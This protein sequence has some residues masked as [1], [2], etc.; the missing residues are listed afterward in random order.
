MAGM[1]GNHDRDDDLAREIR[2]HL[3]LEA[4][5]RV[6][7]GASP[8]EARVAARRAF[9]NVTRIREDARAMWTTPW[10][11]QAQQDV[12]YALRMF[13][14]T[15]GFSVVALLTF[16][17]GIGA[18]RPASA[19]STPF[20]CGRCRLRIPTASFAFP[21]TSRLPTG[22]AARRDAWDGSRGRL[23]PYD[24]RAIRSRT[25]ACTS[26]RFAP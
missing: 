8:E 10:V 19:S 2:A 7:D 24:E 12:L 11:D 22:P 14:R 21:K 15:P 18:T 4:E 25:S 23:Q 3:E 5:E 13:V 16:A 17:L 1:N 6:A 26:R 20:F 9:G